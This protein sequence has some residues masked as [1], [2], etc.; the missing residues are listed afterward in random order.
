MDGRPRLEQVTEGTVSE[1]QEPGDEVTWHEWNWNE[2]W[3]SGSWQWHGHSE[4][5]A[6]STWAA[7]DVPLLPE[8]V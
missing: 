3:W 6:S 1:E 2:D 7:R 5:P 4:P 8:F